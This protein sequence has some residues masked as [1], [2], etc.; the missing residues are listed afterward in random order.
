M[1]M[2][3]IL[4]ESYFQFWALE[5]PYLVREQITSALPLLTGED[6]AR[7]ILEDLRDNGPTADGVFNSF[8]RGYPG[9]GGIHVLDTDPANSWQDVAAQLSVGYTTYNEDGTVL[10]QSSSIF[11]NGRGTPIAVDRFL[12]TGG[13]P[14]YSYSLTWNEARAMWL[15]WVPPFCG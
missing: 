5:D 11:D 15:I 7:A 8:N 13:S 1:W 2:A 9:T 12:L 10:R 6:E 14:C 3:C 4:A